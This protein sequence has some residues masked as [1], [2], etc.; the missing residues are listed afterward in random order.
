[1]VNM[2]HSIE[3]KTSMAVG[4][5]NQQLFASE[6]QNATVNHTTIKPSKH[7]EK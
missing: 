7:L 4:F 5:D 3:V 2:Q 1:M 6:Q